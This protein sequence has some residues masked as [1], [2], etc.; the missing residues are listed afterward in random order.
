M[1]AVYN[2]LLPIHLIQPQIQ[3]LKAFDFLKASFSFGGGIFILAFIYTAF[4]EYYPDSQILS[5][6][7]KY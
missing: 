3:K 1:A 2:E 4:T 6:I 7:G 5:V